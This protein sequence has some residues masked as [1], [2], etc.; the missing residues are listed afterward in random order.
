MQAPP[1]TD[2]A[3][4]HSRLQLA[5]AQQRVRHGRG[6]RSMKRAICKAGP[7]NHGCVWGPTLPV[8]NQSFQD[9]T[10]EEAGGGAETLRGHLL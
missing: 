9:K 10:D 3:T 8:Q 6:Q 1:R 7:R 4:R 5:L 2:P